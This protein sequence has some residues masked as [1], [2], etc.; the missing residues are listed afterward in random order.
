VCQSVVRV[1]LGKYVKYNTNFLFILFF[2]G[3]AYWREMLMDFDAGGLITLGIM[4]GCAF[5]GSD[6]WLT[7]FRG[8]NSP[9]TATN[10]QKIGHFVRELDTDEEW[11]HRRMTSMTPRRLR[12]CKCIVQ[13]QTTDHSFTACMLVRQIHTKLSRNQ[14]N[15]IVNVKLQ[16]I[17][18]YCKMM[19]HHLT[20]DITITSENDNS[21]CSFTAWQT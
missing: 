20:N 12:C 19:W 14:G 8:S 4:Q 6:R 17:W 13:G 3:L 2:F 5:F 1:R 7:T 16:F 10:R 11:R 15:F 18:M 9:K 21:S